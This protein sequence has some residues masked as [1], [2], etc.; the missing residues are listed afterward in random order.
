MLQWWIHQGEGC[1]Y[2]KEQE[3]DGLKKS[4]DL[5]YLISKFHT[6]LQTN[7]LVDIC[8]KTIFLEFLGTKPTAPFRP[9]EFTE[10]YEMKTHLHQYSV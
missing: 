7:T 6:E 5:P 9:V 8:L 4:F 10:S 1:S 3:G 2:E